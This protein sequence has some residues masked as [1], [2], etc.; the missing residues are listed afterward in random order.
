MWVWNWDWNDVVN[1][2]LC[3]VSISVRVLSPG[4]NGDLTQTNTV[5]ATSVASVLDTVQQTLSQG[6]AP[7]PAV[8]VPSIPIAPAL[9][10]LQAIAASIPQMAPAQELEPPPA[11]APETAAPSDAAAHEASAVDEA[12]P[13]L[14]SAEVTPP[15]TVDITPIPQASAPSRLWPLAHAAFARLAKERTPSTMPPAF[16]SLPTVV[17]AGR[18]RQAARPE[19]EAVAAPTDAGR[20]IPGRAPPPNRVPRDG[21][22]LVASSA[23]HGSES[24]PGSPTSLLA[25]LVFLVPGFAQWLWAKAELRPS[26]LR[27]GRPERPG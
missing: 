6:V 15:V 26:A 5:L 16:M 27:P 8:V 14:P 11:A 19:V 22:D 12:A 24:P 10:A 13:P 21:P 3:N 18:E 4:D 9:P 20:R 7:V 1:C 25:L 23:G 17:P 2:S